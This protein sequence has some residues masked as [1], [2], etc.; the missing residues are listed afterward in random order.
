MCDA[1]DGSE[2]KSY[3]MMEVSPATPDRFDRIAG[4]LLGTA[5]E[6]VLGGC[7]A[8]GCPPAGPSVY[9]VARHFSTA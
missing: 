8:R 1:F 6:N 2:Q 7:P 9:L 3:G 4:F 5:E